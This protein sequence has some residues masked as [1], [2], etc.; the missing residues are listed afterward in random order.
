[1]EILKSLTQWVHV[2]PNP[3]LRCSSLARDIQPLGIKRMPETY[4]KSRFL[5]AVVEEI[6]NNVVTLVKPWF[7]VTLYSY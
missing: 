6:M 1:M 2:S 4:K 7:S 5:W 3:E